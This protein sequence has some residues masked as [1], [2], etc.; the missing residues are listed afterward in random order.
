MNSSCEVITDYY[1]VREV[2]GY[3]VGCL[4]ASCFMSVDVMWKCICRGTSGTSHSLGL[5]LA[6]TLLETRESD[7]VMSCD[8]T[9]H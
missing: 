6:C 3:F 5:V 9:N 2:G 7:I 8:D 4:C 1:N